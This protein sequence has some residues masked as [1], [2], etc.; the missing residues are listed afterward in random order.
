MSPNDQRERESEKL[1]FFSKSF[2]PK[3]YKDLG[4]GYWT[5]WD[6]LLLSIL[7]TIDDGGNEPFNAFTRP[8][9]FP[10]HSHP[11]NSHDDDSLIAFSSQTT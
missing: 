9:Y 5:V 4:V 3:L 11:R 10:N 6:T 1:G 7:L 8:K 2:S